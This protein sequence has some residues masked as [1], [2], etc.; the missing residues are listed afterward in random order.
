[1]GKI[2]YEYV[3]LIDFALESNSIQMLFFM[4]K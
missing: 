3:K 2:E 4:Q 1:M